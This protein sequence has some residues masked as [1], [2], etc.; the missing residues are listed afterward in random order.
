MSIN[1]ISEISPQQF[2]LNQNLL[3]ARLLRLL[4]LL[5]QEG[6]T[7]S[8]VF[9][10][11]K[12]MARYNQTY[13]HKEG[14]TNVLSFPAEVADE[15]GD[16]LVSADTAWREAGEK[17]VT[18]HQHLTWL[19]I[20]GLL[21]LLGYDHELSEA[22][23]ERMQDKEAELYQA[24]QHIHSGGAMPQLAVNVDHIA[25]IREARGGAEPDPVLAAGICE[26]AGAR[27]IVVHLREDRRHIQE[28]DVR[29]L[30]QTVKT[31]LNLEMAAVKE[32]VEIA[33]DVKPDL[34]TLVPE[35]RQELTTEGGLDILG[36]EKKIRKTIG[37]MSEAGIPVSLFI[38]PDLEQVKAAVEV[39]AAYVELH[40]GRYADA[41]DH[42]EQER[43][44][45]LIEQA[46]EAAYAAGL[47]V[48]AG[49]GLN[50]LNVGRVAGLPV[51]EELSIGHA[52]IARAAFVGLEQAVREMQ[53]CIDLAG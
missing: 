10:D 23:A 27:G 18:L 38:D 11:D 41:K 32:I 26:L 9:L 53:N 29:V 6:R 25:T 45:R 49:H 35:K 37:K 36:N 24:V 19:L 44:F 16:I 50:Y 30:R 3:R 4:R 22:E 21:H 2:K 17:G 46:A 1:F 15:L 33:L 39:G 12:E 47:R 20:H 13:R 5:K 8:V 40:T 51:I 52:L 43:E 48:N 34:V 14:P 31:R 28:R 7:V 42:E